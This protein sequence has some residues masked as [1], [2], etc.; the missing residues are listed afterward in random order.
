M[1]FWFCNGLAMLGMVFY[2]ALASN[3]AASTLNSPGHFA[4]E[5]PV[6]RVDC[7]TDYH[8]GLGGSEE[9]TGTTEK[10]AKDKTPGAT[11]AAGEIDATDS[12]ET[13][14]G[15]GA[16]ETYLIYF[17]AKWCAPC[18]QQRPVIEEIKDA[19]YTV[20]II[21]I[22]EDPQTRAAWNVTAVPTVATVV[23]NK[24]TYR[25]VGSGHTRAFLESKLNAK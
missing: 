19:G 3:K 1:K 20:Y 24:V 4:G 13:G 15:I 23:N 21:D 10:G 22:D 12:A 7:Q 5:I 8:F 16:A 2:A 25:G 6:A 18:R 11:A 14:V 17:T 9:V